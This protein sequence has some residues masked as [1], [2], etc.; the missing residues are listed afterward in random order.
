MLN[1]I[2]MKKVNFVT[3]D[4]VHENS[5]I[6]SYAKIEE[7]EHVTTLMKILVDQSSKE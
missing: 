3:S 5:L 6:N 7:D 4:M 1:D 2:K